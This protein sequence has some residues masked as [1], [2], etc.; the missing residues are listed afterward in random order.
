MVSVCFLGYVIKGD[1]S[2]ISKI[3][4]FDSLGPSFEMLPNGNNLSFGAN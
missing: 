3:N 2:R 4:Y 1:L